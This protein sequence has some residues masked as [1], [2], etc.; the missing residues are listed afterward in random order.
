MINTTK[1]RKGLILVVRRESINDFRQIAQR[2]AQLDPSIGVIG[3]P[4]AIAQ[5]TLPPI[6]KY[7]PL[8]TIY[9]VNPPKDNHRGKILSVGPFS[10]IQEQVH[11]RTH[12]LPHLPI[13]EFRWGLKLD[14]KIYGEY[15]VLKPKT[16]TSNGRDVNMVPTSVL[17]NL[18][19]GDF[20]KDH[21]IQKHTYLVQKFIKTGEKSS[22]YRVLIFLDEVLVS[23]K[24]EMNS[25][26]PDV[27]SLK[28]LLSTSI[29]PVGSTERKIYLEVDRDVITLAKSTA[30]TFPDY[31]IFG[32]DIIKDEK[33]NELYIL[34]ANLGGNTWTFSNLMGENF[35]AL[36]G[37]QNLINQYGAWDR[38]AE[39]LVRKTNELAC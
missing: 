33:T 28:S 36:V 21:L 39:A 37:L 35:R 32:I 8:L 26:Y 5:K 17:Q 2:V 14:P 29:S 9:L 27:T 18:Q 15:V 11:F 23:Y 16:A 1:I 10:K 24:C 4:S 13:Q 6:F 19:P 7:V 31:P 34:E 25:D 3:Y 12:A 22:Y 20:D 30:R 38:A